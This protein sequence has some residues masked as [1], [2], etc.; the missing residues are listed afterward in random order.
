[1]NGVQLQVESRSNTG[2]GPNRRLRDTG[3]V[4]AIVYGEGVESQSIS[5]QPI[6]LVGLLRGK[7]GQNELITLEVDGKPGPTVIMRD[8]QLHPVRRTLLHVDFL[9]VTENSSLVVEVPVEIVGKA[10]VEKVGGKRRV[11]TNT[12]K[13]RC[14]PGDIPVAITHDV[15]AITGTVVVYVDELAMPEG[16]E[17]VYRRKFPIVSFAAP[18]AVVKAAE[19][20]KKKK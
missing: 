16:C 14:R 3:L 5:V 18:K 6:P 9:R 19:E 4:P 15:S 12:V 8:Y 10:E 2:K 17:I 1:M 7:K 11:V 13:V 20:P